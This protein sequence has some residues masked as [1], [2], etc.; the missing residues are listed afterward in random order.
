MGGLGQ[1]PDLRGG[2]GAWQKKRGVV[3]LRVVLYVMPNVPFLYAV[4][5]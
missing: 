1:F 2:R 5:T 4:K 3:F